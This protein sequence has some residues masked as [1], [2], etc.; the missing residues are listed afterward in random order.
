MFLVRL[1]PL[2]SPA[3]RPLLPR[4]YATNWRTHLASKWNS[5]EEIERAREWVESLYDRVL[6]IVW[7]GWAEC[8]QVGIPHL[9]PHHSSHP[10]RKADERKKKKRK[11]GN[12]KGIQ[13]G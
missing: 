9:F 12:D 4:F 3:I 2:L 5:D 6:S 1:R 8:Q 13:K 11:A 10:P 7:A